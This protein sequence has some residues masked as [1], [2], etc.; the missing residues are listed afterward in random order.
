MDKNAEQELEYPSF[1]QLLKET[2]ELM[3]DLGRVIEM[4]DTKPN[5]QQRRAMERASRKQEKQR[6]VN[7]PRGD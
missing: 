6:F 4:K 1:D 2:S 3:N 7:N 5:R